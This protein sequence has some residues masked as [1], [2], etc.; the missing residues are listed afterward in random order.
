MFEKNTPVYYQIHLVNSRVPENTPVYYQVRLVPSLDLEIT[1]VYYQVGL[2]N[3]RFQ[4]NTPVYNQVRSINSRVRDTHLNI[5]FG[6]PSQLAC[7]RPIPWFMT[8]YALLT[9]M[10]ERNTPVH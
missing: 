3:L 10:F 9:R 2:V 5:L 7:S 8:K 6:A 1:Q 4:E